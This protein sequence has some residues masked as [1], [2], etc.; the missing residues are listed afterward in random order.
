MDV[1]SMS[2]VD[3]HKL[4]REVDL[5]IEAKND[6]VTLEGLKDLKKHVAETGKKAVMKSIKAL[7]DKHPGVQAIR[8]TQ[9]APYYNDGDACVFSVHEPQVALNV[10]TPPD[11][12]DEDDDEDGFQGAWQFDRGGALRDDLDK[13]YGLM[14]EADDAMEATFGDSVQV[15]IRRGET[16]AEV[17]DYSHD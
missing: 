13:L 4:R 1:A 6:G 8:W 11:D 3:L 2:E 16:E 15:T 5:A 7:M 12:E 14:C 9:Y 17:K 10:S